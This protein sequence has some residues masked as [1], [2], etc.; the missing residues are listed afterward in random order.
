MSM[1][2]RLKKLNLI[3]PKLS[4]NLMIKSKIGKKKKEQKKQLN[5]FN[6]QT[7]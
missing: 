1:K 3:Q 7:L 5:W 2:K 4:N 6:S